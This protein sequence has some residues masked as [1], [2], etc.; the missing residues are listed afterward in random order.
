MPP[1][2][3][4]LPQDCVTPEQ[5]LQCTEVS[6]EGVRKGLSL[7]WAEVTPWRHLLGLCHDLE[8]RASQGRQKSRAF[9]DWKPDHALRS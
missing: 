5:G 1:H 2:H 7:N 9:L 3:C 8:A 6:W 4:M